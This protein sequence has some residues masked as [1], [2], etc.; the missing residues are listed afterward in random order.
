MLTDTHCHLDINKFDEDRETVLQRAMDAGIERI[1]VPALDFEYS[2][3]AIHLAQSHSHIYAAVGFHPTDLEKWN[4]A[5]I[6]NL[7]NLICDSSGSPYSSE[8]AP[9]LQKKIVAIGEIGLDYYWVK[10]HD[11][12]AQQR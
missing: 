9:A 8:L 7:H 12:R 5:S 2:R 4:D 1:L 6:E 10:E 11:K 3:S